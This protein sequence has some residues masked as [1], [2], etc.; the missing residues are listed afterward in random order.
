MSGLGFMLGLII[1]YL[2]QIDL[3]NKYGKKNEEFERR[4]DPKMCRQYEIQKRVE[5][6]FLT[7]KY[8]EAAEAPA[9]ERVALREQAFRTMMESRG[10]FGVGTSLRAR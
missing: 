1:F 9:A 4:L 6:D 2:Y 8:A 7:R 3:H 10:P 5:H